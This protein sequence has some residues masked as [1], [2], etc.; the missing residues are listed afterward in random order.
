MV[1]RADDHDIQSARI[2]RQPDIAFAI[3][4]GACFNTAEFFAQLGGECFRK[5]LVT[6]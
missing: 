1:E 2:A 5:A 3:G 4:E 6:R